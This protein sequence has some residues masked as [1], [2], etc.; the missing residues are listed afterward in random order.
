MSIEPAE[1]VVAV[2]LNVRPN[3]S[4]AARCAGFDRFSGAILGLTPQAL[5]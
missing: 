2:A 4:A 3:D 5:R 1:R